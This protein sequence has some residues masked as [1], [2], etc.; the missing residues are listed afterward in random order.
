MMFTS[1][2]GQLYNFFH[3]KELLPH[4]CSL[5]W[6]FSFHITVS[7]RGMLFQVFKILLSLF[8]WW[9]ALS[10]YTFGLTL[11]KWIW[12]TAACPTSGA[13]YTSFTTLT[14]AW[15]WTN[16]VLANIFYWP[17]AFPV[18]STGADT[19][20][21]F[22]SFFFFAYLFFWLRE[23]IFSTDVIVV[24]QSAA[25]NYTNNEGMPCDCWRGSI[26]IFG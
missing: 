25:L 12:T 7:L 2:R 19:L 18:D 3:D 11:S 21:R 10:I 22:S 4:Q 17:L 24:P 26:G 5:S 15:V 20:A 14:P 23:I 6:R 8:S 9:T 16:Y 13:T 1:L